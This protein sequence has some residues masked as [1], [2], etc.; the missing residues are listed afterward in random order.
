MH[1]RVALAAL[2]LIC[3][4]AA[5]A[6]SVRYRGAPDPLKA[7]EIVGA[8]PR[9]LDRGVVI[10]EVLEPVIAAENGDVPAGIEPLPVDIFTTTDFYADRE[11]WHDPRYYR[12]NSPTA[13]ESL[14]GAT[15]TSIMGDDPPR[16]AAWG[17]CDRDYPRDEIVSSY[18]FDTAKAHYEAL[19]AEARSRGGPTIYT[20]ATLPDWNGRYE[21]QRGKL[22]SWLY[23]NVLQIPTY[24]SLLTE[25]YQRYFVQQAYHEARNHHQWPAT[26][27]W[28]EGFMRRISQYGGGDT[29]LIMT[30]QLILDVR[31]TSQRMATQI[32]IEREFNEDGVVPRLGAE[33]PRWYGETIGFWD[34]EALITWT[35]NIQGWI[36]HGIHEYSN[37]PQTIEIYTPRRD[38]DDNLIGL[39]H[40]IVL[41]DD[42]AFVE[43]VRVVQW[44]DRKRGLNEGE[45]IPTDACVPT[46]YPIDGEATPVSPGQRIEYVVPDIYGRPWAKIWER[47]HEDGMS[48]PREEDIFD[49]GR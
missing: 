5:S 29:S 35:S 27:C 42:E 19:K 25:D 44:L 10:A 32:H 33:V 48:Q 46:I 34:G 31:F 23:G 41:Y 8:D 38:E 12:C 24:L 21:R 9:G 39:E 18:P 37:H 45:P 1:V 2:S 20:Q 47:Y 11:L 36:S 16:T 43:P 15:R 6:Q 13:L 30:P 49:L 14:G 22:Q 7:D 26:Y 3:W 4:T 40:E 17:Y 28:P